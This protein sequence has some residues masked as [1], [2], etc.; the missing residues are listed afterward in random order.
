[1]LAEVSYAG[2]PETDAQ[3]PSLAVAGVVIDIDIC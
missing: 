2:N 3:M 1:M